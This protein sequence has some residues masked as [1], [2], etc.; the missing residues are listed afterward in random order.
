MVNI[1]QLV[2]TTTVPEIY[3]NTERLTVHKK[4]TFDLD[5]PETWPDLNKEADN[6]ITVV[7]ARITNPLPP[8]ATNKPDVE[9]KLVAGYSG[10]I[11]SV[12]KDCTFF[13]D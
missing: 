10:A 1:E 13:Y 4:G 2:S 8:K 5:N 7:K 3:K 11:L 9:V 12:S 6:K